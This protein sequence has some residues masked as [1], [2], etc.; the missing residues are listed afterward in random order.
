VRSALAAALA[1]D[2]RGGGLSSA[3]VNF[4]DGAG[5][6]AALAGAGFDE[7]HGVQYWF[8]NGGRGGAPAP[9]DPFYTSF[10]DF[11][12]ALRQSKRKLIRQE[13]K[14]VRGYG[15]SI[16]RVTGAGLTPDLAAAMFDFYRDTTFRRWGRTYL[17]REFFISLFAEM[18]DDV[19]LVV[20]YDDARRPVAGA[21]NL[22]GSRALFGRH[23]GAARGVDMPGLHFEL[24]YYQ[25][26]EHAIEH[27]LSR[28]EAG[29]QGE[30][31]LARGYVPV[32]Q[33]SF[34]SLVDPRLDAAVR[35]FLRRERAQMAGVLEVLGEEASPYKKV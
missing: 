33:T 25:A 6:A 3:H 30:H 34:H 24:S 35:D 15:L 14:K 32:K 31:K 5:D 21:L 10:A 26:I 9:G 23:W 27:G 28:V 7:R 4:C 22:V 2:A 18:Q 19:L 8:F 29:A 17:T 11:E 1:A 12:A 13:R 20:A 16:E